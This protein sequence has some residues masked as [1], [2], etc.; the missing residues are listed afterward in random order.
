MTKEELVANIVGHWD[1]YAANGILGNYGPIEFCDSGDMMVQGVRAATWEI[2]EDMIAIR[3]FHE[4]LGHAVL[5]FEDKDCFV[6]EHRH[7]S[8]ALYDWILKRRGV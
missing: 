8:G 6:G 3:Y 2:I 7:K 4:E 1:L 5:T